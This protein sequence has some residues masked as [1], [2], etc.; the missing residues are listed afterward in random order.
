MVKSGRL[1]LILEILYMHPRIGIIFG[2][3][4]GD[5]SMSMCVAH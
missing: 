1:E 3:I 4:V 2:L 5:L